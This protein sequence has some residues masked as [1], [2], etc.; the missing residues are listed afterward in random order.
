M[1]RGLRPLLAGVIG[2]AANIGIFVV[3]NIGLYVREVTIADWRWVMILGTPIMLGILILFIVP[4]SP[5]WL[6]Q[7]AEAQPTKKHQSAQ[8]RFSVGPVTRD[9]DWDTACDRAAVRL[10]G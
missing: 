6:A 7:K 3:G 5:R 9:V 8:L 10:L 1:V 4:E 2:T